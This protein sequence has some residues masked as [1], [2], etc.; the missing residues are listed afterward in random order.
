MRILYVI[1]STDLGGAEQALVSLVQTMGA[2]HTVRVVCLKPLG[3]LAA[4][5]RSSG[6][7]VV[8]PV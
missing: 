4:A 6:A 7:T 5:L 1:T 8:S 3:L 2:L